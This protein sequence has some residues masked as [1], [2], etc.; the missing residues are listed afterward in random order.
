MGKYEYIWVKYG[1]NKVKYVQ[2]TKSY[3]LFICVFAHGR[4]NG[5]RGGGGAY[6]PEA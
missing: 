2:V 6:I 4:I 5:G 1:S 3:E